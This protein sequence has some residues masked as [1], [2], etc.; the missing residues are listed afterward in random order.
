MAGKRFTAERLI[1][2]PHEAEVGLALGVDFKGS[3][4]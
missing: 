2:K 4:V 1:M 3:Q